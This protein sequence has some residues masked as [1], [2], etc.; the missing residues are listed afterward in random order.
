[1]VVC[2]SNS[3]FGRFLFPLSHLSAWA[4]R[5][6]KFFAAKEKGCQVSI[7][8]ELENQIFGEKKWMKRNTSDIKVSLIHIHWCNL[9]NFKKDVFFLANTA[10]I[11]CMSDFTS[12]F[13]KLSPCSKPAGKVPG[14]NLTLKKSCQ[15][16]LG[17]SKHQFLGTY[18][19]NLKNWLFVG[20]KLPNICILSN[21]L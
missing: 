2:R 10:L 11:C 3:T 5:L 14:T 8:R 15:T 18:R 16:K 6:R 4:M 1:M 19:T 13:E 12:I 7:P 17:E 9:K 21:L 20:Q